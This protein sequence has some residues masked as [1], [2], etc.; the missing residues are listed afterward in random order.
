MD[1]LK[2]EVSFYGPFVYEHNGN[3]LVVTAPRCPGHLASVYSDSDEK[4]LDGCGPGQTIPFLYQLKHVR[5]GLPTPC[6]SSFK[7]AAEAIIVESS[8]CPVRPRETDCYFR[9]ELPCPENIVGLISDFISYVEHDLPGSPATIAKKKATAMRFYYSIGP[10]DIFELV[11]HRN[12]NAPITGVSIDYHLPQSH[13]PLTFRYTA[14]GIF[15][16]DHQDAEECFMRMR[17]LFPRLGSWSV[18]F[19][20]YDGPHLLKGGGDC[21]AAAIII[22]DKATKDRWLS[23]GQ[24]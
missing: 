7:N 18:T 5:P 23:V 14:N 19:D 10:K 4:A 2:L 20:V 12:P 17:A 1:N 15:E 11:E 22:A 6:I 8:R 16:K 24:E 13:V 21:K 9:V 3:I